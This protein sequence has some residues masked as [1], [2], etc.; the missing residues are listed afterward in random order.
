MITREIVQCKEC[1][2]WIPP[3]IKTP[4]GRYVDYLGGYDEN[5][6][7]KEYVTLSAGVN[8]QCCCGRYD[9][10]HRN[11]VPQFMGPE[12]GCTKGEVLDMESVNQMKASLEYLQE[13]RRR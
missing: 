8:V 9:K 7:P 1:I 4:D 10:Y 11:D 12:D 5:G 3:K 6:F 13:R 2:H